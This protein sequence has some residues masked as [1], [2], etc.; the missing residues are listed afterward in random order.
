MGTPLSQA[1]NS[2]EGLKGTGQA[3]WPHRGT[4][5]LIWDSLCPAMMFQ[6]PL[7]LSLPQFPH[8]FI[9]ASTRTELWGFEGSVPN[10]EGQ[11]CCQGVPGFRSKSGLLSLVP[12]SCWE[13]FGGCAGGGH[14][15]GREGVKRK[16]GV[17]IKGHW[18]AGLIGG[19][20]AT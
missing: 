12:S 6:E 13:C 7:H 19:T 5:P 2:S 1:G 20:P 11:G 3:G 8:V 10:A 4:G 15:A 16:P 9:G 18:G 17:S 14:M